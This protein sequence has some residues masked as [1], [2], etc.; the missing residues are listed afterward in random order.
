MI[1]SRNYHYSAPEIQSVGYLEVHIKCVHWIC[2]NHISQV[3]RVYT[4][5]CVRYLLFWDMTIH[6]CVFG[7]LHSQ[8]SML[9]Q[10]SEHEIPTDALSY[11]RRLDISTF[12]KRATQ[13]W[14]IHT[15]NTKYPDYMKSDILLL[16]TCYT[17][18]DISIFK[19]EIYEYINE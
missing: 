14:Y 4:V 18:D 16:N 3:L 1:L 17:E 15:R 2:H 10:N 6:Y 19:S 12:H 5:V 11:P 13:V 8:T 7:S 9:S